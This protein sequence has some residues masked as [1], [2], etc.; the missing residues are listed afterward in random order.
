MKRAPFVRSAMLLALVAAS[1]GCAMIEASG[2]W[3]RETGESMEAYS[4]K[5]DGFVG[6]LAGFGGRVNQAVG[7]T[8]ESMASDKDEPA[9]SSAPAAPMPAAT[10]VAATPIAPPPSQPTQQAAAQ[11]SP[12]LQAQRRLQQLGYDVG[13]P[14]GIYGPKTRAALLKHQR[15]QGL[16]ATGKLD[17]ATMASLRIAQST[18]AR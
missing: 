4:K 14:D 10:T 7:G 8:V 3:T 16:A 11:E 12:M 15:D 18:A 6:S 9:V 1:S 13:K 5:N 2:R 17:Q